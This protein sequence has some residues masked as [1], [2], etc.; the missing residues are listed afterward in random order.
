[1]TSAHLEAPSLRQLQGAMAA[2]I[3][4]CSSPDTD[5]VVA[6]WVAVPPPAGA[7]ERLAVYE[8]GYPARIHD[9]LAD[10]HPAL[11]RLAGSAAFAALARRYAAAVPLASYNLNDAGAG[12]VAFL[13]DDELA[14]E[15][16]F[17]PD[18]AALEQAVAQAFHAA[19][20]PPLD[21]A[22]VG[23]SLDEWERAVLEFQPAV[24]VLTSPWRLLDVWAGSAAD[25]GAPDV[26]APEHVLIRRAGFVV[27]CES[28]CAAEAAALRRLLDGSTLGA[29]LAALEAEG[30]DP[31]AVGDWCAR[32]MRSGMIAGA[33][34]SAG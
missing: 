22:T 20:R 8:D 34:S 29:C 17:L 15:R 5:G 24:T 16:R 11:A 26:A 10:V 25:P 2:R 31:A 14:R 7:D 23:W 3:L 9:A 4:G 21:P 1:M 33:R 30:H 19:E 18:L 12:L 28:I 27:R 32:W 6:R 13:A